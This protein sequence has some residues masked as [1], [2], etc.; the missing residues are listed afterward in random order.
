MV[1]GMT[2]LEFAIAVTVAWTRL[3]TLGLSVDVARQRRDEVA[4]DVW[5][6][7]HDPGATCGLRGAVS[8]LVRLTDGVVDDVAWRIEQAPVERQLRMRRA[9]AIIAAGALVIGLWT[10]PVM[11]AGG[12]RSVNACAEAAPPPGTR[13]EFRL[14][15]VR[16]A[17]AFFVVQN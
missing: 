3:Y 17:G 9:F 5:D 2:S 12:M 6:M 1:T 10:I 7:T 4:S 14:E 16:C 8:A 11:F 13:S 15:L